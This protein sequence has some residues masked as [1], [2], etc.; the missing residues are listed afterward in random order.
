MY[1][2]YDQLLGFVQGDFFCLYH[3]IDHPLNHHLGEDSLVFF[4]AF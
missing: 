1:L 2:E 3:G 4:Q